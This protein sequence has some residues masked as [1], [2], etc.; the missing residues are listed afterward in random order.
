MRNSSNSKSVAL[1]DIREDVHVDQKRTVTP[2]RYV[3]LAYDNYNV[4]SNYL[5]TEE[6]NHLNKLLG[7]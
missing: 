5:D 1:S 7:I 3:S 6:V 4:T 2:E